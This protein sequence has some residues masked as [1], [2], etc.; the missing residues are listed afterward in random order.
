MSAHVLLDQG[1][2][3]WL[4]TIEAR[5]KELDLLEAPLRE[6]RK[7]RERL[8]SAK[9]QAE[10]DAVI[11]GLSTQRNAALKF[12]ETETKLFFKN[13]FGILE[14]T[15]VAVENLGGRTT[16]ALL[17]TDLSARMLADG[18]GVFTVSGD[19]LEVDLVKGLPRPDYLLVQE[20]AGQKFVVLG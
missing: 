10:S 4:A 18:T 1:G 20:S 2:R 9:G 13:I 3:E 19:A 6:Q 16:G 17:A 15:P 12:V 14:H 5:K 7:R 11:S 8:K